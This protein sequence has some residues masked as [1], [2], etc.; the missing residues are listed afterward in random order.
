[1]KT[2][3]IDEALVRVEVVLGEASLSVRELSALS[4]GRILELESICGEPIELRAA[5]QVLARGEVV[6][7]DE[8]FGIRLTELAG[9]EAQP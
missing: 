1:M 2:G 3:T 5:G 4:P 9:S 7:I 8:R 6:V